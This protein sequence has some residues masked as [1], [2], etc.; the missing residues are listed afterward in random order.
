M[1]RVEMIWIMYGRHIV[2]TAFVFAAFVFF[3]AEGLGQ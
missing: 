3:G 1:S 2:G